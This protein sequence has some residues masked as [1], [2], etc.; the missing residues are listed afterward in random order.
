MSEIRGGQLRAE[1]YIELWHEHAELLAAFRRLQM[2]CERAE[3]RRDSLLDLL[4]HAD[5]LY[6]AQL[7]N[8]PAKRIDWEEA[9]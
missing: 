9:A 6:R 7:D 5:N 2:E 4:R 8:Q 3:E 1:D